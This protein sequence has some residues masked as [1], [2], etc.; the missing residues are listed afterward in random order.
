MHQEIHLP[1]KLLYSVK[2]FIILAGIGRTKA[3]EE[4]NSG[5]LKT[6]FCGKRRL[7]PATSLQEWISKL[8][9]ASE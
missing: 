8:P 7:V 6:V 3:Y 1:T 2:E 4:I 5:R 9:S